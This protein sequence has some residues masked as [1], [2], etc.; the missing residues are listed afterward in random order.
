MGTRSIISIY[1]KGRF[2]VAQYTQF[3]GYPE[4]QGL[5]IFKFLKDPTNLIHLKE[6]LEHHIYTPTQEELEEIDEHVRKVDEERRERDLAN[7]TMSWLTRGPMAEFYP[8]LAR[9]T[10][11]VVLKIIAAAGSVTSGAEKTADVEAVL[12]ALEATPETAPMAKGEKLIPIV[13]DLEF[14]NDGL[15]CEWSYV[16]DLDTNSFEVYSGSVSKENAKS[17]RWNEVGDEKASVPELQASF[18]V[19]N[20]PDEDGYFEAFRSLRD[21]DEEDEE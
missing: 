16:V 19:D 2:V 20:L 5:K 4:G 17:K 6:G 14:V 13:L 12:K 7:G 8:S 3:D 9:E 10:G 18:E 1:Y 11:A 15:F 21:E